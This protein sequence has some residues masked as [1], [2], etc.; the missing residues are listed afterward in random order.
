MIKKK[1]KKRKKAAGKTVK[2]A[3]TKGNSKRKGGKKEPDPKE[4][5]TECAKLIKDEASDMTAAVIAAGKTGQVAP[6]KFLF[7]MAHIF[8]AADDGSETS[9]EEESLAKTLLNR[10][11][12]PTDPVMAD[13]DEKDDAVM[14]ESRGPDEKEEPE[15]ENEEKPAA[16]VVV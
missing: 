8:P 9:A 14:D 4:V 3:A 12:I 15:E 10:L 11:G 13:E 2:K 5:R 6:V 16:S 1:A 7:E